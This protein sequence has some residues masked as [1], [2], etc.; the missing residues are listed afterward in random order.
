[1]GRSADYR[2]G[3]FDLGHH[4]AGLRP[5][6]KTQHGRVSG[7]R[8]RHGRRGH[9]LHSAAQS[10]R[11]KLQLDIRHRHRSGSYGG[12]GWLVSG[13][14]PARR[15]RASPNRARPAGGSIPD[16]RGC[17]HRRSHIDRRGHGFQQCRSARLLDRH[18]RAG[19]T[20]HRHRRHRSIG[21]A[22]RVGTGQCGIPRHRRPHRP[23]TR[24]QLHDHRARCPSHPL[25]HLGY[26]WSGDV[27]HRSSAPR[28]S[29]GVQPCLP[30]WAL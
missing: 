18:T 25:R 19:C 10:R 22:G 13:P 6:R 2:R 16:R 14:L 27:E 21:R 11:Q 29:G 20:S 4:G 5:A 9:R 26:R 8:N 28:S 1:M 17:G 12:G 7:L 30:R 3:R 24:R 23:H 15:A